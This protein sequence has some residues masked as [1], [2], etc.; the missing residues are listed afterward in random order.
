MYGSYILQSAGIDHVTT[1]HP[2]LLEVDEREVADSKATYENSTA[3]ESIGVGAGV[4][5]VI[6]EVGDET[7]LDVVSKRSR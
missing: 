2:R 3:M 1:L 5:S 6:F 4:G 7:V